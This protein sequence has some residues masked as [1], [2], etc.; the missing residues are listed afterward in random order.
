M[1][2]VPGEMPVLGLDFRIHEGKRGLLAGDIALL[3]GASRRADVP[4]PSLRIATRDR[5]VRER[6]CA[7]ALRLLARH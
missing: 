2:D 4:F 5:D 7:H 6:D 1:P 3:A